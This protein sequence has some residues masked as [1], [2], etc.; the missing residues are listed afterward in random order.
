MPFNSRNKIG[1]HEF[2]GFS[3]NFYMKNRKEKNHRE[4][5][6]TGEKKLKPGKKNSDKDEK[7]SDANFDTTDSDAAEN[8]ARV[9]HA[10]QVSGNDIEEGD[11]DYDDEKKTGK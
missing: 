1:W 2:I 10:S 9:K 7:Y 8:N 4:I 5:E 3:L 11:E 6:A